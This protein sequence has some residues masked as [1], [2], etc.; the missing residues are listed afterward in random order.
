MD[1]DRD[2]TSGLERAADERRVQR[3]VETVRRVIQAGSEPADVL[4]DAAERLEVVVMVEE[5]TPGESA[6]FKAAAA[7]FRSMAAGRTGEPKGVI[8]TLAQALIE[9]D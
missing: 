2:E 7:Y 4:I 9:E 3:V 6:V 1:E 8:A 5:P